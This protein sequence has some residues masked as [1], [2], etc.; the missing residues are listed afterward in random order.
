MN[1]I[2][3]ERPHL[4]EPNIYISVC[5]EIA[6]KVCPQKLAAAVK[7]AFEAN[8]ATMSKIMLEH[9]F[10]YYEKNLYHAVKQRLRMKI[11]TG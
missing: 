11:E 4:F 5:V 8:E 9:G 7:K 10:A 6:G 1:E 2:I 3:T